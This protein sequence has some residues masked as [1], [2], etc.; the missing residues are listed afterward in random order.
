MI[1]VRDKGQ[2]CNNILQY[3]HLYAWGREMQIKTVS[4]RFAYKYQYF[5]ICDSPCH[6]FF[7]YLFAKWGCALGLI[8]K[9]T[10]AEGADVAALER[11]MKKAK[12]IVAE[13]WHVQFPRLFLKYREEIADLFAFKQPLSDGVRRRMDE[14]APKPALRLGVHIRRGDYAKWMGGRYFYDDAVYASHIK[15]FA[16]MHAGSPV[17]VFLSSNDPSIDVEWYRQAAG[18]PD[19]FR[20]DGNPAE[21]LCMLS[22][23]DYLIGPPSTFSLVASFYHDIPLCWLRDRDKEMRPEDFGKFEELFTRIV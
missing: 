15:R 4:M 5:R 18:V 20:L 21:D 6:N 22:E 9:V 14:L 8:P 2:M 12:C 23:C 1:F 10:F 17:A 16:A 7:V 11:K 19:V 3:G 13:G